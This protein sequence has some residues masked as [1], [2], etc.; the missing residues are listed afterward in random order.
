MQ[1]A[2]IQFATRF[3]MLTSHRFLFKFRIY[4]G[5]TLMKKVALMTGVS[6]GLGLALAKEFLS[7]GYE[8]YGLSRREPKELIQDANFHFQTCDLGQMSKVP[9]CL[10][11]LLA[12]IQ[13][14]DII[15][16]NAGVISPLR[17]MS[18]TTLDEI[19][20]VMNVNVWANKVIL[21]ELIANKKFFKQVITLS[22]GASIKGSLGWSSYSLSKA[23]L[24]MLTKLYAHEVPHAHF[25]AL[26]P[27]LVSTPMLNGILKREHVEEFPSVEDLHLATKRT[28]EEAAQL[29]YKTFPKLIKY[30][31]GS[32]I[33]IRNLD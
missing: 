17:K 21:D 3:P 13:N 4:D 31:S 8:V 26:A 27:G 14:I 22:S 7:H 6:S 20:S 2:K 1:P 28:P 32:Y 5:R 9:H 15:V 24:N 23:T 33:D 25:T 16:L 30:E 11:S 19:Q 12:N 29:L 18:E 10:Q